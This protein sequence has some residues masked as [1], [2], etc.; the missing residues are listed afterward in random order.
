MSA[1]LFLMRKEIKN[2]FLEM[3]HH[4]ARLISTLIFV[5]A[6][7]FSLISSPGAEADG[8]RPD[9]RLLHGI[10]FVVLLFFSGI[11]ILPGLKSG[12][13][14]FKMADVNFLFVSPLSPT[15]ILAYGLVKQMGANLVMTFF[16]L[17]YGAGAVRRFGLTGPQMALLIVGAGV[18]M[19]L[20]QILALLLYSV[21]NGRP[22]RVRIAKLC[23][24]AVPCAAAVLLLRGGFG[25]QAVLD[26]AASPAL[27]F[28]PA[29]GWMKG[30]VFSAIAGAWLPAAGYGAALLAAIAASVV[31]LIRS[32][33]D[34][35]E[36]V[37]Q[38]TEETFELQNAVKE[39]RVLAGKRT[40]PAKVTD[41]GINGGWGASTIFFKHLRQSRRK[42][43]GIPFIGLSTLIL[44]AANLVLTFI[45]KASGEGDPMPSEATLLI[46]L[47]ASSYILFFTNAA[48]D[49]FM[50][51]MKPYIYLIPEKPFDKLFWAT[52]STLIKPFVDGVLLFAVLAV[53][54]RVNPAS[55][56][57]C[58]LFYTSMGWVYTS[59]S[60][61]AQ[62]LFGSL[63]H[64]G[65]ILIFYFFTL[66]ALVAPGLGGSLLLFVLA[67]HLP[68]F[69][70]GLPAVLCN[71][72]VSLGVFAVCRNL[73]STAEFSH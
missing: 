24:Y 45:L 60:V 68:L 11:C 43:G 35:Y 56:V 14:F 66:L 7:L 59:A 8:S 1:V 44:I 21:T 72:L 55:A 57:I 17:L 58:I 38:H 3:L 52:L 15:E 37:L 2:A 69:V 39:G 6:M 42:R 22:G 65:L 4:P 53:S 36:D 71:A 70:L 27:S 31:L 9:I 54:L 34:Y 61:L 32:N 28:L 50:E 19:F 29:V 13:T 5:G 20:A 30:F 18:M 23:I 16:L 40:R 25:M 33:P 67:G 63:E 46:C 73:L 49:W 48:G 41:T 47:A 26:A 64:K 10:Y 51:L 12:S 62:R